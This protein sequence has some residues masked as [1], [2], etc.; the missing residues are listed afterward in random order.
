MSLQFTNL[1]SHQLNFNVLNFLL[2]QNPV[3]FIYALQNKKQISLNDQFRKDKF[4]TKPLKF[5]PQSNSSK[6]QLTN[7]I[8]DQ[9]KTSDH[10]AQLLCTYCIY[11]RID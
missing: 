7:I 1:T 2:Q 6:F 8:Q 3:K 5:Y 11:L 10:L 9:S 4:H